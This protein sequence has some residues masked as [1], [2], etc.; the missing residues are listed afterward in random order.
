MMTNR[1]QLLSSPRGT[2]IYYYS[3]IKAYVSNSVQHSNSDAK[4]TC[5]VHM[6]TVDNH[7]F[8]PAQYA[9]IWIHK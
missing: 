7:F 5:C 8:S 9:E 1:E 2:N 4:A 6:L 3:G